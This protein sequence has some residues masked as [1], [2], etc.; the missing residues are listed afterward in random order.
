[1]KLRILTAGLV[2]LFIMSVVML[3]P[4]NAQTKEDIKAQGND[5]VPP[6]LEKIPPTR[7]D[8]LSR[9]GPP[10]RIDPANP[11]VNLNATTLWERG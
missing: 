7:R 2:S 11:L 6:G 4:A 1:M 10:S 3:F 8:T 9:T 5:K